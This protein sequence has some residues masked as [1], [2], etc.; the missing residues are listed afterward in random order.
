MGGLLAP[1]LALALRRPQTSHLCLRAADWETKG[2]FKGC[3]DVEEANFS[4]SGKWLG[5][6][7]LKAGLECED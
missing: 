2:T 4:S 5:T 7:Q 6:V 1:G 3:A